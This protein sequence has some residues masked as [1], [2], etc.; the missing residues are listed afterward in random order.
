MN[1]RWRREKA[2]VLLGGALAVFLLI[3]L[4]GGAQPAPPAERLTLEKSIAWALRESVIVRAA[5]EGTLG[6]EAQRQEALTG[7]LPHFSTSYGYTRLNEAPYLTFPGIPPLIPATTLTAG[8]QD[9][10]TWQVEA[11]QP[12]FAGGAI[13]A[14]YETNRLGAAIARQEQAAT[15]QNLVEEVQVNYFQI[16]KAERL[17]TV[18]RQSLEQR[19]AHRDTAA[20][21]FSAGLVPRNDLLRAEVELANGRQ[22]LLRA[23][24]ALEMARAR[25]NTLLR[26]DAGAPLE[27]ED[28][29]GD[30]RFGW[31]LESCIASAMERRPELKAADLRTAQARSLV[32][33]AQS[34]YF[35]AVSL[36]G[37]YSKY[38][39]TPAVSGTA[40]KHQESWQAMVLAQWNFWEWGRSMHRVAA[41][42]SRENQAADLLAN[43]R[44]Q[45]ALEV[46]NAYLLRNEAEQQ[47]RVAEQAV[48]QAEENFRIAQ[49]RYREQV[50]AAVDVIDAETLLTQ[51][52]ADYAN[53]VMDRRIQQARLARAIGE[54]YRG[55]AQP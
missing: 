49:E 48:E 4:S 38:G 42:R 15:V 43:A 45:V 9:N 50:G 35:P 10:Y 5:R 7:F 53:A 23:E 51:A 22:S 18:A 12:L 19:K 29:P 11:R 36:V 13:A 16:L 21:F 46:R 1:S 25:F 47:V 28:L 31:T 54:G 30:S 26:R 24:N 20:G 32:R 39:D 34:E 41:S 37:N 40:Y 55:E 14:N 8:T 3:P 2:Q 27:L 6:A 44:D 52:R 17:L 33:S